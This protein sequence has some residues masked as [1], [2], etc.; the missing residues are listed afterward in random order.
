MAIFL[1]GD[2]H[3]DFTRFKK[4][5]FYE[6][7]NLTKEDCVIIA[8]DFGGIWDGSPKEQYWL[9]WL[10]DKSFT[11]LFV[12]GNHENFAMLETYPVS[13]WHGGKV[14]RIRPSVLHLMRGQL[15]EIGGKRFFTMGGASSHPVRRK[16][17]CAPFPPGGENYAR[18]LAPHLHGKPAALGF[19]VRTRVSADEQGGKRLVLQPIQPILLFGAAVPYP[20]EVAADDDAVL[21]GQV[22][23]LV[24]NVLF[25]PGKIA[26]GVA[27]KENS[28]FVSLLF[29]IISYLLLN[30]HVAVPELDSNRLSVHD[31]DL[32][33]IS[34]RQGVIVLCE[35]G[36]VRLQMF[37]QLGHAG[38]LIGSVFLVLSEGGNSFQDGAVDKVYKGKRI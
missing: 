15:Y 12:S 26:V 22:R 2:T 29:L 10:E 32:L 28:H 13:D 31:G 30:F 36:G 23:L 37:S 35:L 9:D 21:F 38:L 27:G 16:V 5:S 1:T 20:A 25:K 19:A 7:T 8:G 6:Q 4:D 3:G 24:E 14:Q 17:R 18:S 33:H 34:A 11:T